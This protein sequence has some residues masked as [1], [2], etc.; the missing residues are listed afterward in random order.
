MFVF[1]LGV[2]ACSDF[3][4]QQANRSY[5]TFSNGTKTYTGRLEVCLNGVYVPVCDSGLDVNELNDVCSTVLGS[6]SLV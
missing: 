5:F 3:I 1:N 6:K 2:P 4:Y